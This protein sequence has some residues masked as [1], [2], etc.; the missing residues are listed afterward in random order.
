VN[1]I[2]MNLDRISPDELYRTA[3]ELA[4]SGSYSAAIR[5]YSLAIE[6]DPSQIKARLGRGI[7]LQRIGEHSGAI[8]D[9]DEV[10]TCYPDWPGAYIAYYSRAASRHALGQSIEAVK[11][12]DEAISRNPDF[13]DAFYLRGIARK[14]LGRIETAASDMDAV[15]K[16]NPCYF[17]A[18]IERG[19]L[20]YLQHRCK[21]AIE[22]FTAAIE[23]VGARSPYLREC[24]Y[25][26]GIAAQELGEHRAAIADFTRAIDL[27]PNDG[28]AHLHRARS[29]HGLGEFVAGE[30]DFQLGT[31]L[32]NGQ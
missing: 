22:E 3:Q 18:H 2:A 29:Y 10:I 13:M 19:K 1:G 32:M 25:L 4:A 26:R 17:E 24:Y 5:A 30:A 31:R 15:L 7:A 27:A 14:A 11:D 16:L 8:P 21:Q 28:S 23:Y 9:F 6:H 12:C 20:D